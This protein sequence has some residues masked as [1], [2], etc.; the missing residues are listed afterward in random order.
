MVVAHPPFCITISGADDAVC[1]G[2]LLALS[3]AYPFV[4]W[5]ILYC[6][7]TEGTAHNPS[8]EW[9]RKFAAVCRKYRLRSALHLW[10]DATFRMLL[11]RRADAAFVTQMQ[12][13]DRVQVNINGRVRSFNREEVIDV[14][15]V[16]AAYGVKLILQRHDGSADAIDRFLSMS[17]TKATSLPLVVSVLFDASCGKGVSPREWP[18]PITVGEIEI[19]TGYAGG[20]SP[21]NI[22]SVLD[23]TAIAVRESGH[24][25]HRYW[26]DMQ[27]GVRTAGQFDLEKVERILSIVARRLERSA[28]T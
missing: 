23:A 17:L 24:R 28:T 10:G 16:L 6:M 9:R 2:D 18:A 20:I 4:E 26:L 5:G 15:R 8:A 27:S 13:Y 14:Y 3:R 12:R 25:P 21:R 22:E 1:I 11:Q 7:G 19:D